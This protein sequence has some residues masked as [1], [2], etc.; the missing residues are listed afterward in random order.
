MA[1][2]T[3]L[4]IKILGVKVPQ[5]LYRQLEKEAEFHKMPISTYVRFLLNE[6]MIDVELTEE[7]YEIIKN[8]IAEIENK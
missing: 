8:R 4:K 3:S 1:H 6:A 2:Q 7:D 5:E